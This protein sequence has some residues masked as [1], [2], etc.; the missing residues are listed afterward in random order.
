MQNCIQAI[1]TIL[2]NKSSEPSKVL[3]ALRLA[4]DSVEL[5]ND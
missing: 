1:A 2:E 5:F 4:K 3:F